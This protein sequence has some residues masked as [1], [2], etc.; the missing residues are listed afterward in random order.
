MLVE[1]GGLRWGVEQRLAFIESRLFWEGGVNRS[2]LVATFDVSVPQASK[3]LALYQEQAPN[4]LRYDSARKRY[5]TAEAFTARFIK[6]DADAY[7]RERADADLNDAAANL[8]GYLA[9]RLPIPTRRVNPAVLRLILAG[10]REEQSVEIEYQSMSSR[11]PEPYWRRISPHAFAHDGLR[12]H[13][14]AYCHSDER[15]LDF[16]VSRCLGARALGPQAMP[17]A[18]D[19]IWNSIFGVT[20]CPNPALSGSQQQ[21]VAD[22][23]GM[24]AG[25]VVVPVRRALL[26]YFSKRLRLDVGETIDNPS[27]TPVIVKNRDAFQDALAEAMR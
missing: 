21:V 4:N 19:R 18:E 23:Y 12:W 5:V 6:L 13:V 15:F 9:E 8:A 25:E 22:D 7:L 26:Y 14:R 3:D 27:E 1:K 20:L 17:R 2:D 11:R 10:V 24:N 16:I